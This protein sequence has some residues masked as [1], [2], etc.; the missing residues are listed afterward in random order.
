[1]T[2]TRYSFLLLGFPAQGEGRLQTVHQVEVPDVNERLHGTDG[3]Q[4]AA[5]VALRVET[6]PLQG[7]G[8][9]GEE[10]VVVDIQ[11]VLHV[12]VDINLTQ[13]GLVNN[14]PPLIDSHL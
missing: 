12:V 5:L 6:E 13:T 8:E 4:A 1:M 10:D 3:H 11:S 9:G 7:Q 14:I 2:N